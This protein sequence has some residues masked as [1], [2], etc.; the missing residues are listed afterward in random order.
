[1]SDTDPSLLNL[2]TQSNY[3]RSMGFRLASANAGCASIECVVAEAHANTRGVCHG[4]VI[5]GLMDMAAGVATKSLFA[6]KARAIATVS[7]TVNYQR[8][9]EVGRTLT[10]RATV[11]S[12]RSVVSCEVVVQDDLGEPIAQGLATLAVR[13]RDPSSGQ[14]PGGS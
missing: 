14:D 6:D 10:A 2:F 9:A 1:M 12:G 13:R 7:L 5:S 4:G 8:P 11:R 3:S